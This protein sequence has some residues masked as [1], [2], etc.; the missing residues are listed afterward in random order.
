M[1]TQ[2]EKDVK[3]SLIAAK[4]GDRIH[5]MAPVEVYFVLPLAIFARYEA[6]IAR[7]TGGDFSVAAG[8]NLVL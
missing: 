8:Y 5:G 2:F 7:L 3:A 4:L 6:L 1:T